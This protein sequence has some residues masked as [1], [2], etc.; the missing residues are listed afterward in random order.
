MFL[1]N[2]MNKLGVALVAAAFLFSASAGVADAAKGG[3]K[4]SVPKVSAP[5]PAPKPAAPAATTQKA[6]KPNQEYAP[7]KKASDLK[8]TPAQAKNAANP[9][10]NAAAANTNTGSR[11]G[12]ALRNIGLL[13]GGMMLGG[14]LA[15]MFGMGGMF[16]DILGLLANAAIFFVAFLA[17][18]KLIGFF[19]NKGNVSSSNNNTFGSRDPYGRQDTPAQ[20]SYNAGNY[21]AQGPIPDIR[22]DSKGMVDVKPM[23]QSNAG[24][25]Y[26]ARETAARYRRM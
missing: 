26:D 5:K 22:R 4:L 10:A 19:M 13:A 20:N 1:K 11:W 9:A 16:G 24:G 7:S 18:K 8:D 15:N 25:S 23:G 14:M 6:D 17:I 3:A 21:Q 12:S 2:K